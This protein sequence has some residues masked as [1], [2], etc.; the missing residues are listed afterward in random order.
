M[1]EHGQEENAI[2]I[3]CLTR[4]LSRFFLRCDGCGHK[5]GTFFLEERIALGLLQIEILLRE[6]IEEKGGIYL[7]IINQDVSMM[8]IECLRNHFEIVG[9]MMA[10]L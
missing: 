7:P 9:V 2:A 1:C 8:P 4:L 3:T 6:K 5:G 10:M